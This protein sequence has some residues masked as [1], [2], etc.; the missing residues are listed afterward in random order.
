MSYSNHRAPQSDCLRKN[1]RVNIIGVLL[2][3][4]MVMA[5]VS[6]AQNASVNLAWDPS[7][8]TNVGGYN[9]YY[10]PSTGNYTNLVNTGD[11]TNV[12]ISG[13]LTGSTYYFVATA[14][15]AAGLE[16]DP[17][18]EVNYT[19]G[20]TNTNQVNAAPTLDS[21]ADVTI[22]EDAATQS[23]TLTGITSGASNEVQTL[24]VTATSS[25]PTIIPNPV[26]AYTSPN[27]TGTLTFAPLSNANGAVIV[28]VTVND[29]QTTNNLFSRNFVVT[30]YPVNDAPTLNPIPDLTILNNAGPQ[31]VQLSGISSGASNENQPLTVIATSSNPALIPNPGISYTSPNSGGTLTFAPNS[32]TNGVATLIVTVNDGQASNNVVTRSF[33]VTVNASVI[34][35]TPPTISLIPDQTISKNQSTLP[36]PVVIGDLETLAGNLVLTASTSSTNL[37][38]LSQI[39]F[40]GIGP[41]RT[42]TIT[43]AH[44]KI[45]TA[46][47]GVTVSD[48]VLQA[49]TVFKLT[50]SGTG[51]NNGTLASSVVTNN[52]QIVSIGAESLNG[53]G[54]SAATEVQWESVSGAI[55]HVLS[56]HDLGYPG[57]IDI[58]G[59]ILADDAVTSWIDGTAAMGVPG[60][61]RIVR[62][63]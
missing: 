4:C 60:F 22:A 40:G 51:N 3:L 36:L 6:D 35:N 21:I 28:T 47:I 37:V 17:S 52:F 31:L 9:V 63:Q 20:V 11:A 7:P 59:D 8:D 50:V 57:W 18:N 44:G 54:V 43:P 48:G 29:G 62:I 19:P 46:M 24:T 12:T 26:I 27:S 38:P 49:Q 45:G 14:F 13:L 16:S 39:V 55:Y 5:N 53:L 33:T 61:Y 56:K 23:L 2:I 34:T 25:D 42:V 32:A 10:G 15:D 30:V 58:S 1:S 41:A